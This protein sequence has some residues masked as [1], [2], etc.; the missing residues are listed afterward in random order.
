MRSFQSDEGREPVDDVDAVFASYLVRFRVDNQVADP[1]FVG[2]V[3]ES[4]IYKDFVKSQVGGAAQPNA[5]AQVLGSFKFW[6]PTRPEHCFSNRQSSYSMPS[7]FYDYNS[8]FY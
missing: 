4:F 1:G 5:N 8:P 6:L 7:F 3:V 2:R